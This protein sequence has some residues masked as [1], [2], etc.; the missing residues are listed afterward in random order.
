MMGIIFAL[1]LFVV[2]FGIAIIGVLE[3]DSRNYQRRRN[4]KRCIIPNGWDQ[5]SGLTKKGDWY[6]HD[7]LEGFKK[8][9]IIGR[10]VRNYYTVIRCIKEGR[11]GDPNEL[12][13]ETWGKGEPKE[14]III[15]DT[16]A[17]E[18][19]KKSLEICQNIEAKMD[20]TMD[21]I[22]KMFVA[23]LNG[24]KLSKIDLANIQVQLLALRQ[25]IT[26][27]EGPLPLLQKKG[28]DYYTVDHSLM[29]IESISEEP[30]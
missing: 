1:M 24:E 30:L 2:F 7:D 14:D 12:L 18:L 25:E 28:E 19:A 15:K 26:G 3:Q 11:E 20:A 27:K 13:A 22:Q 16:E 4:H 5:V 6:W 29:D 17:L 23:Q 9:D 21:I 8:V 10:S